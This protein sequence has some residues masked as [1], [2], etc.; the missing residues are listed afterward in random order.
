MK[1]SKM[2]KFMGIVTLLFCPYSIKNAKK[3][4]RPPGNRHSYNLKAKY[5]QS[6]VVNRKYYPPA[7]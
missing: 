7:D 5:H 4:T 6:A 3:N 2:V 1:L